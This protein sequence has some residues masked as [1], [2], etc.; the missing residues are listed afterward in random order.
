[1]SEKT[2][3]T[4]HIFEATILVKIPDG[5]SD[6]WVHRGHVQARD[7]DHALRVFAT[8]NV[9]PDGHPY[10]DG[11]FVAVS[12]SAWQPRKLVVKSEPKVEITPA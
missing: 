6:A 12:E 5:E 4:F 11:T 2:L 9:N 10:L 3:T 7:R 8:V 1:M